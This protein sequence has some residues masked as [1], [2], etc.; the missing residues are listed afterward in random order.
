MSQRVT[1]AV[2]R[3]GIDIGKSAFHVIGLDATGKPVFR[4]RFTR[5][6]LIEFLARA[7]PTVIGMEVCPGAY[8]SFFLCERKIVTG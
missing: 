7:S 2:A 4:G 1:P 5:E 3:M 6:R 8:W